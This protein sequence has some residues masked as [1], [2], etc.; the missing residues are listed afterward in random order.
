MGESRASGHH[1]LCYWSAQ[2]L[3][4]GSPGA[5]RIQVGPDGGPTSAQSVAYGSVKAAVL[6]G[7]RE[8]SRSELASTSPLGLK[9]T[10]PTPYARRPS[11]C[12]SG[13][14]KIAFPTGFS[15]TGS[16]NPTSP[17]PPP[18]LASSLP[19]GLK[20]TPTASGS[21]WMGGPAS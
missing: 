17:P 21:A 4:C 16:H 5:Y 12:G 11:G 13:L 15:V 10:S 19:S 7:F 3:G 18:A 1:L 20:A 14:G 2:T 8:P 9:A 6:H